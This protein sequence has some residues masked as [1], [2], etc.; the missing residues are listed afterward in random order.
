MNL[1]NLLP[2]WQLDGSRGFH[3][4]STEERWAVA[5]AIGLVLFVT[6]QRMLWIV[7][8]VAVFR[9]VKGPAGPGHRPTLLTFVGLV[10]ALAWLGRAVR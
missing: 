1:F 5:G 3:A 8:A 7:L 4:L 9:A 2:I 10:A 6:G